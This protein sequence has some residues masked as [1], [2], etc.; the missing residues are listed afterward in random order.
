[1]LE[2]RES[3]NKNNIPEMEPGLYLAICYL[4]A[5]IGEHENRM[6]NNTSRQIVMSWEFPDE[7]I[8]LNGQ[9]IPRTQSMFFTLSLSERAR[10]RSF[11]ENW[12]GRAFTAEELAGFNV[13]K[14]LGA[15]CMLNMVE[16]A[17]ADGSKHTVIGGVSKLPKGMTAPLP[18]MPRV[19]FD[20]DVPD[21]IT[22][23]Q[24]LPEWIQNK[25]RESITYQQMIN[26]QHEPEQVQRASDS[27]GFEELDSDADVP[28]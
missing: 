9:R 6:Y 5:D 21:A 25:I 8:E 13:G 24:E 10:L 20:L 15:A 12:R 27:D 26:P 19:L 23:M 16:K 18:S 17:R 11:L 28:F 3:S 22:Q 2:A 4:I 1:M 7:M 14:V